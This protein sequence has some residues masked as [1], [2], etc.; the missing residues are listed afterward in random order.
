MPESE[1]RGWERTWEEIC[2][3]TIGTNWVAVA[4][5]REIKILDMS[6]HELR[7]VAFDRQIVAMR[8]YEN[9]LAV[10]YH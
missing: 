1:L 2:A 5:D 4:S 7:S 9:L 6:S 10:L 8:A 3:V